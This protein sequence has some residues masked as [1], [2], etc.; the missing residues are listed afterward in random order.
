MAVPI[1]L[2]LGPV[3]AEV[4][5][6]ILRTESETQVSPCQDDGTRPDEAP[7][8][9]WS[10]DPVG[11][12]GSSAQVLAI[13]DN[14]LIVGGVLS[15]EGFYPKAAMLI[16]QG[17]VEL[18]NDF[19]LLEG[20]GS[21]RNPKPKGSLLLA[22]L[23]GY[24]MG[25]AAILDVSGAQSAQFPCRDDGSFPDTQMNDGMP[26]CIGPMKADALQFTLVGGTG[27]RTALG[28]ASWSNKGLRYLTVGVAAASLSDKPFPLPL[29]PLEISKTTAQT[30][31]TVQT[32]APTTAQ[33]T[34][35]TIPS[36]STPPLGVRPAAGLNSP[37]ALPIQL[38]ALGLL[39]GALAAHL[40]KRSGQK[41]QKHLRI[42][43][44]PPVLPG[45][46]AATGGA[47]LLT[48]TPEP[49]ACAL[50]AL[51]VQRFRLVVLTSASVKLPLLAGAGAW[52]ATSSDWE[53]LVQGVQALAA[54][55]GSPVAVLIVGG[56]TLQD[57]GDIAPGPL[58]KL[59]KKLPP[60]IWVGV[61]AEPSEEPASWL[62]V[63]RVTGPPWSAS[64]A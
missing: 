17:K 52:E 20:K 61:V 40:R 35:Q 13:V 8:G 27:N 5:L 15:F 30:P 47:V 43:P 10:C 2:R 28:E 58:K 42:L 31:T 62:P 12:A 32:T 53:V 26:F 23:D 63:Y 7:D 55:E 21:P 22:R 6:A 33:T 18:S 3:D 64:T 34:T 60:G 48:E 45:L 11:I 9:I 14:R 24:G 54:T 41:L 37:G 19:A 38:L 39:A 16:G 50:A 44:A 57:P 59:L 29:P 36:A 46:E 4:V 1:E 51:L 25:P 49:L 56:K